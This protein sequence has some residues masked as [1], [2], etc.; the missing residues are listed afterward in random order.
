MATHSGHGRSVGAGLM[1]A[2][3]TAA[4]LT[5]A[6]ALAV[7]NTIT[8]P[9]PKNLIWK[10]AGTGAP[11]TA[12][13]DS[14]ATEFQRSGADMWMRVGNLW[15]V[16]DT[17]LEPGWSASWPWPGGVT[18]PWQR[19]RNNE[20]YGCVSR[21][22]GAMVATRNWV[23]PTADEAAK[24]RDWVTDV[25]PVSP[26]GPQAV[27][28]MHSFRGQGAWGDISGIDQVQV[29]RF[30]PPQVYVNGIQL[31]DQTETFG[32]LPGSPPN[33]D[34]L[35]KFGEVRGVID[36]D[37]PSY[38]AIYRHHRWEMGVDLTETIH[39][40][41]TQA[42]GD[43]LLYEYSFKNTGV[44]SRRP[45]VSHPLPLQDFWYSFNFHARPAAQ[46]MALY[47]GG[48]DL[49]EF[50]NPWPNYTDA[51]GNHHTICV[52]YDGDKTG[53]FEDW[54]DPGYSVA[55]ELGKDL[56]SKQHTAVG[57]VFAETAP[58]TSTDD[59]SQPQGNGWCRERDYNLNA[60]QLDMAKQYRTIFC[61]GQTD[62]VPRRLPENVTQAS[63]GVSMTDP[64]PYQGVHW[65]A[66]PFNATVR[67]IMVVA[68]GGLDG[69]TSRNLGKIQMARRDAGTTPVQTPAEIALILTGKDSV[70]K[71]LDR[72]FWNVYGYDPN[73]PGGT[74]RWA[75]KP[76]AQNRTF[77]TPDPPPPPAVGW[78]MSGDGSA[79]IQWQPITDAQ[80][81]DPDTGVSD[82]AGYRVY[83]AVGASDSDYVKVYEGTATRYEDT[84]VSKDFV[85]YY[86]VT[87]Y[88]DGTQNWSNSNV[89]LESGR[90]W[91]WNGWYD[92]GVRPAGKIAKTAAELA[93]I[94]VVPNPYN[95][96][97]EFPT[98]AP[99]EDITWKNLPAVCTIR[100]YTAAGDFVHEIEHIVGGSEPWDMRTSNNQYIAT[101]VYIYTV[102]SEIGSHVGKFVVIR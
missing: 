20:R 9:A 7:G 66:L 88:D 35:D 73:P 59:P 51:G 12:M 54:G 71:V 49:L 29:Q 11:L 53:G 102:D 14:T 38:R 23:P 64:T 25:A 84:A 3:L 87:S 85:Y 10:I 13:G 82:F 57:F 62:Y 47:G 61:G 58:G 95:V 16:F 34:G 19:L 1:V 69:R 17:S 101:G 77:N 96:R 81:K 46:G 78:M 37:L 22:Q 45:I 100:I 42:D 18:V 50:I 63:V 68:A 31:H 52:F 15:H 8:L 86:Y 44:M 67:A 41:A 2:A 99:K 93:D 4:C 60:F 36:P 26:L 98:G 92:A 39:A 55:S 32:V 83:R 70:K 74:P 48:D 6:S 80:K 75:N 33:D 56:W 76:T 90:F 24:I 94:R 43:Y 30:L 40:Y 72:V 97:L 27:M 28:V 65:S 21:K 91:V 5:A 89:K 79:I